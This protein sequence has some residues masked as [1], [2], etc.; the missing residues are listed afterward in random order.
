MIAIDLKYH[1]QTQSEMFSKELPAR[2]IFYNNLVDRLSF[3]GDGSHH[4]NVNKFYFINV[5]EHAG[6]TM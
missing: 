3:R 1:R 6:R 4:H 5:Y 2:L